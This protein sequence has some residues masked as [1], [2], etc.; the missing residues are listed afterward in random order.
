LPARHKCSRKGG[1]PLG[2][3]KSALEIALERGR[4]VAEQVGERNEWEEQQL[5]VVGENLARRYLADELTT[6]DLA[7]QL[8]RQPEKAR[9]AVAK[10]ASAALA[11]ELRLD[12]YAK[13]LEGVQ[14]LRKEEAVTRWVEETRRA[15]QQF[16]SEQAREEQEAAER[17]SQRERAELAKRGIGGTAVIGLNFKASPEWHRLRRVWEERLAEIR[18]RLVEFL[19]Q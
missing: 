3:I 5:R 19:E 13:V 14:A 12:N 6:W 15:C 7:A 16:Q 18:K 17:W 8:E 1:T 2:K 10:T 11:K 4:Q 9:G